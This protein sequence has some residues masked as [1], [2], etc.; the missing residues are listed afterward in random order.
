MGEYAS[1]LGATGP[2]AR[3]VEGF[4]PRHEQQVMADHVGEAIADRSVLAVEA[5]RDSWRGP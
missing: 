2:L 3:A 4:E 1:L 5:G